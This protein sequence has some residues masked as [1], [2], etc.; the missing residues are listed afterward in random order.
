MRMKR[1]AM[2]GHIA[3]PRVTAA[4]AALIFLAGSASASVPFDIQESRDTSTCM[5]IIVTRLVEQADSLRFEYM[6]HEAAQLYRDAADSLVSAHVPDSLMASLPR[7]RRDSMAFASFSAADSLAMSG[8]GQKLLYAE[9]GEAMM[10]YVS[11]PVVVSRHVFSREDFFL[12][13]PLPDRSWRPVPNQL[14]SIPGHPYVKATYIP[15]GAS[16]LYFSASDQDGVRNI[17]HTELRDSLW[18]IPALLNEGMVSSGDDIYPML[19]PD[20]KSLYFSSAGLYGLG[21]YDIYESRWNEEQNCWGTPVNMG[22]PF[23]SPY[24]DFLYVN[25]SDGRYTVFASNRGCSPDSVMVYVLE[26]DNMPLRKPAETSAWLKEL[27]ALVPDGDPSRLDTGTTVQADIPDNPE[28]R[29]YMQKMDEVRVLRDSIDFY[30]RT[31]DSLRN[32]YAEAAGAGDVEKLGTEIVSRES[33]IPVL[34][35]SLVRAA[36]QLQ[37]IE[38]KFLFSGVVIDPDKVVNQA[39]R[40]VVGASTNYAFSRMSEGKPVRFEF[41]KPVKKFDYSFMILPEGRFAE[42]NSLPDGIVYQIQMCMLSRPATVRQLKGLSPVFWHKTTSGNYIYRV[43]LFRTYN[44]VL[45]NLNKVRR[46]GFK[47][48]FIVAFSDRE[49]IPVQKART[50]ESNSRSSFR[51]TVTPE[52]QEL[53]ELTVKAIRQFTDR[54]IAK[55][56]ENG[57]QTYVVGPFSS[58]EEA[59][60]LEAAVKSTGVVNVSVEEIANVPVK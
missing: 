46:L 41:E 51:L 27:S 8:I 55:V 54:D 43:G 15:D 49:Q 60:K 53:P 59:E 22:F 20:G 35:D 18:S 16:E 17:Y 42:D 52:G 56:N 40:E 12:F 45:S 50:L 6:F 47:T 25:T 19:S 5:D 26:Y 37:E 29:L 24:D 23:S 4:S 9:N 57:T 3:F 34:Q 7:E 14:D 2:F 1:I 39:D 21:G 13:Y 33:R 48:A 28:T 44:D 58:R 36:S 30:G 31:L 38:M 10:E 11:E 32:A